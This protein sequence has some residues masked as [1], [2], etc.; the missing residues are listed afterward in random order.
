MMM[1]ICLAT[2]YYLLVP[3]YYYYYYS[4]LLDY[5]LPSTITITIYDICMYISM[6]YYYY[7]LLC[8]LFLILANQNVVNKRAR[9]SYNITY[10]LKL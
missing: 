7:Y 5:V 3:S 1:N 9:S 8:I 10:Y 6:I 2:I 4:V